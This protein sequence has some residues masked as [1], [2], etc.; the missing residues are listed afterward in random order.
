M[1]AVAMRLEGPF[2]SWGG[3]TAGLARGTLE[4]P[5]RSGVMGI[6]LSAMGLPGEQ[7]EMLERLSKGRME[8]VSWEKPGCP[9]SVLDDFQT[10]GT[11]YDPKDPWQAMMIPKRKDGKTSSTAPKIIRRSILQD[12]AFTV[13]LEIEDG[14]AEKIAEALAWP[15]WPIYLGRAAYIP[16]E[17]IFIGLADDIGQARDLAEEAMKGYRKTLVVEELPSYVPG[18]LVLHDVPL[19]FGRVKRYG[20]RCVSLTKLV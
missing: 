15:V 13:I 7:K 3:M 4:Y 10:V 11:C 16:S 20:T 2:Q 8:I 1:K 6:L 19:Q 9:V 14:P 17:D 12:A 18:A 5:T